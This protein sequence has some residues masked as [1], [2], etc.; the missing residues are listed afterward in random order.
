MPLPVPPLLAWIQAQKILWL[1]GNLLVFYLPSICQANKLLKLWA[2]SSS[3]CSRPR[4]LLLVH[5]G[6]TLLHEKVLN[7][8]RSFVVRTVSGQ[9]GVGRKIEACTPPPPLSRAGPFPS[10]ISSGVGN[11]AEPQLSLIFPSVAI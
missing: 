6:R 4:K 3:S 11:A 1:A 2:R 7:E 5:V 9:A 8:V 10:T